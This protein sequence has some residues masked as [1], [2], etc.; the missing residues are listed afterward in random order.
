MRFFLSFSLSF[1]YSPMYCCPDLEC[2]PKK[3]REFVGGV[4]RLSL[5]FSLRVVVVSSSSII[6]ITA[7]TTDNTQQQRRDPT[8]EILPLRRDGLVRAVFGRVLRRDGSKRHHSIND[9]SKEEKGTTA[10][11]TTTTTTTTIR[12][13]DDASD[14]KDVKGTMRLET[15]EAER[16]REGNSRVRTRVGDRRPGCHKS[17]VDETVP[18]RFLFDDTTTTIRQD[19]K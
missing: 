12:A 15:M 19:N 17:V 11:T 7:G 3:T 6:I 18:G 8:D 13:S 4:L 14:D 10:T 1:A 9:G 5:T 2:F 16:R